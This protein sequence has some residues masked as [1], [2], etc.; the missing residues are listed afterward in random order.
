MKEIRRIKKKVASTEM[1][2]L[3]QYDSVSDFDN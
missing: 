3:L 2:R 1:I